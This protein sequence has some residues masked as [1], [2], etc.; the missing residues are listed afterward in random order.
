MAQQQPRPQQQRDE[1]RRDEERQ[2]SSSPSSGRSHQQQ[3]EGHTALQNRMP[4]HQGMQEYHRPYPPGRRSPVSSPF[5]PT[6]SPTGHYPYGRYC[7]DHLR[8]SPPRGIP[9]SHFFSHP[10]PMQYHYRPPPRFPGMPVSSPPERSALER[11]DGS[12]TCKK[13]K[14]LKLYC[15]CF[16]L[17]T[18]CGLKCRCSD[19]HNTDAH[20]KDIEDAR[21]QVL[22]R[23]PSA[24]E[25]K[26]RYPSTRPPPPPFD[27]YYAPRTPF[28]FSEFPYG[29]PP[30]AMPKSQRVNQWGC[31]CRKSFCLKKYCECFQNDV[32]CGANCRC[33]NCKNIPPK[34]G[35]PPERERMLPPTMTASSSS[36]ST[37]SSSSQSQPFRVAE[38][39]V[40]SPPVSPEEEV[41]LNVMAM[42]KK[43]K[44]QEK[45]DTTPKKD[46]D[47]LAIMA[48]VAMTEL[49]AGKP[50]AATPT[51]K[52][53]S[54][55]VAKR[56]KAQ[57]ISP[58]NTSVES[59]CDETTLD[60][61]SQRTL[62]KRQRA[63]SIGEES[64]VRK[65]ESS[66]HE[67]QRNVP[68][69]PTQ[70]RNA[71]MPHPQQQQRMYPP[72]P[73]PPP[74]G[75]PRPPYGHYQ[76]P[77]PHPHHRYPPPFPLSHLQSYKET[78]RVSGLPKS[79]SF[80]KICSKCGRTRAEHGELGFGNK[81]TFGDCGKC[82][83]LLKQHLCH[84]T[85][86]GI[87]CTLKEQ[88]GAFPGASESYD[89]K[90]R[91]LAARAELQ[92]S[93]SEDKKERT[94]KLARHMAGLQAGA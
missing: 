49:L 2:Q 25:D 80:R 72:P 51:V 61:E 7:P 26:F 92:K 60:D 50:S 5:P 30:A 90:I 12:C 55:S 88:Q 84:K 47:R 86:M 48:A 82:G 18:T 46:Q 19:C 85:K 13:S 58:D 42:K 64:P 77:P 83:A 73:P 75:V 3:H 31:K 69:Q 94:Q 24:F 63:G 35:A 16:A 38:T 14:C 39:K 81:C 91:N 52:S 20:A 62:S 68:L 78:I 8:A 33:L 43:K 66:P 10:P 34:G 76:Y 36:T 71:Y 15:Q 53:E 74:Y 70:Y 79:L 9:Q 56:K 27:P 87:L 57:A 40:V 17:S 67:P 65:L 6:G 29:S 89:R 32:F 11:N 1:S 37:L 44:Q 4:Q 41:P 21:K 22:E 93:M 54:S 23:N 45:E 59:G 28:R